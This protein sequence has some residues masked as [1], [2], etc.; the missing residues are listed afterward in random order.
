MVPS[1]NREMIPFGKMYLER[2]Q[3]NLGVATCG[4]MPPGQQWELPKFGYNA[5]LDK[6]LYECTN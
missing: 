6:Y 3:N 4:G 1:E 5:K 2:W